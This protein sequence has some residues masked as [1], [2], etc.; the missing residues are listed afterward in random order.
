M[1][2]FNVLGVLSASKFL[3]ALEVFNFLGAFTSGLEL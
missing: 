2:A 3:G 1:V